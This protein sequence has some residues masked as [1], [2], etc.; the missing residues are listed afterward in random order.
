MFVLARWPTLTEAL[1]A[2]ISGT[3]LFDRPSPERAQQTSTASS[4]CVS[5]PAAFRPSL[6]ASWIHVWPG[7]VG[8]A[9]LSRLRSIARL[10]SNPLCQRVASSELRHDVT[11]PLRRTQRTRLLAQIYGVLVDIGSDADCVKV[12]K[13]PWGYNLDAA[14]SGPTRT[15][16]PRSS[17]LRQLSSSR[18][19]IYSHGLHCSQMRMLLSALSLLLEPL[20]LRDRRAY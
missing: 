12:P 18:F 9:P 16:M 3:L 6:A 5:N 11:V 10:T 17:S 14:Q 2:R 13:E 7:R 1:K 19:H 15:L 20:C 4:N 8:A